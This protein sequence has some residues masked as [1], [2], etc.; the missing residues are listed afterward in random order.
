MA[1][2]ETALQERVKPATIWT[3]VGK[4]GKKLGAIRHQLRA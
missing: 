4:L 2:E 1:V 3:N